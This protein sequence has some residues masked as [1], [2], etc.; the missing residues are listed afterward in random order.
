MSAAAP[1][2]APCAA[3]QQRRA[4]EL[5]I[6]QRY[7][8]DSWTDH[9]FAALFVV[10]WLAEI[11]TAIWISPRT[12]VASTSY[13][14]PHVWVAVL[15]GGATISMPMLM[16]V[17][18]PGHSSTRLAIALAQG[19]NTAILIHLT[20]GRIETHFYVFVSLA[21]L[22]FYRDW[23]VLLTAAL[24][25][26][27]DHFVRGLYW[28]Q[29]VYGVTLASPWR[30]LEHS[31][32]VA[33]EVVFLL[34]LC[35]QGLLE[36]RSVAQ[37]QAQLEA[38]NVAT[39]FINAQ[40]REEI[41]ERH[42]AQRALEN[43]KNAA[44]AA[45]H[46][47]SEF[48]ANMSH[49]LRTPLNSIIGF[50]DVLA[51]RISGPLNENQAQYVTDILESGQHLLSLVNDVLDLAKIE[52]GSMEL[53]R[54]PVALGQ[55]AERAVQMFRERAMRHGIRLVAEMDPE[56]GIVVADERRLKQLLYNLLSNALKFTP[57]GG[58]VRVRLGQT[59]DAVT[60]AVSDTGIG[61]PKDQQVRI[62]ESF[63]QVDSSLT[64]SAQGT[65]LG[66]AMVR[67]ICE[68]H[69]G[70]ILVS[71]ELNEG[72]TFVV[73]LP[74]SSCRSTDRVAS[75]GESLPNPSNAGVS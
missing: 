18:W 28:P 16:I 32:W 35:R 3:Q 63:Y 38:T 19:L 75:F 31:G 66:L 53:E 62:F 24:V 61:I 27:V 46:A 39:E 71:S 10:Q 17:L 69:G 59:I 65:G 6:E 23:R 21:I 54:S 57:A 51:E 56:V 47:K 50:A 12:W 9:L 29:S 40:L 11:G 74:K 15:L 37:R 7:R 72:S 13:V 58:E 68:L 25:V 2:L 26:A 1:A 33:M 22:A 34:L 5:F 64:K 73:S 49:E 36:S 43:A 8:L 20:G 44:E 48:L 67:Q 14:H 70:Q 52:S 30:F 42:N 55:L 41:V 60:V 45:S 4:T